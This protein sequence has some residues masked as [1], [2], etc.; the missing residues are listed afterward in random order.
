M[1]PV[2]AGVSLEGTSVVSINYVPTGTQT[3]LMVATGQPSTTAS[4]PLAGYRTL[5]GLDDDDD[6]PSSTAASLTLVAAT[7]T[8]TRFGSGDASPSATETSATDGAASTES[9]DSGAL[10]GHRGASRALMGGC[11][12]AVIATLGYG[13]PIL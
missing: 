3:T 4:V 9:P 10:S 2:K 12:I 7:G 8:P 1:N 11:A 5:T 13:I 6:D